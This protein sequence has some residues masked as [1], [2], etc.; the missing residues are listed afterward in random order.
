[1]PTRVERNAERFQALGNPIRLAILRL[2]VQGKEA[3]TSVGDIQK[4]V[5]IPGSTLS[6]HL[7]RLA[8]TGL[9]RVERDGH[10]LLYR[11]DFQRLHRL[12]DYLWEDCCKGGR[13]MDGSLSSGTEAAPGACPT[14][15]CS[16]PED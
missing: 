13:M 12:T 5:G 8:K 10:S 4:K 14:G 11:A 7:S 6:H 3:G 1:M 16:S 2:L 15:A 9:A